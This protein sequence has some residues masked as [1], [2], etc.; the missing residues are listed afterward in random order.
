MYKRLAARV[1]TVTMAILVISPIAKALHWGCYMSGSA[2]CVTGGNYSCS[3]CTDSE[4]C[5]VSCG[6]AGASGQSGRA[7]GYCVQ[8]S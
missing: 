3:W 6:C 8:V 5:R 2:V 1:M 4:G 7:N